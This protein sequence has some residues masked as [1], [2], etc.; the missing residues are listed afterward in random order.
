MSTVKATIVDSSTSENLGY[1]V[2]AV[3]TKAGI[4][5]TDQLGPG[6][7]SGDDGAIEV[8][9]K[10]LDYENDADA[11][12]IEVSVKDYQT[13]RFSPDEFTGN[14]KL[15][16]TILAKA[17]EVAKDKMSKIPVW[18]WVSGGLVLG[19]VSIAVFFGKNKK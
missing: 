17:K 8:S 9:S 13:E 3:L 2:S 7:I 5:K 10:L 6:F 14:L 1:G 15:K 12:D 4:K 11:V 18:A 16:K 19:V